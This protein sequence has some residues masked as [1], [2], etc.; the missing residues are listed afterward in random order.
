MDQ[1]AESIEKLIERA[2]EFEDRAKEAPETV[3][4][5]LPQ[6]VSFVQRGGFSRQEVMLR[7]AALESI[8]S[9]AEYE[10]TVIKKQY[11]ELIE[12]VLDTQESRLL[13]KALLH[14]SARLVDRGVSSE[15][16]VN[17]IHLGVEEAIKE[18][19]EVGDSLNADDQVPAG[20]AT[21]MHLQKHLA[22]FADT[23]TGREQLAVGALTAAFEQLVGY[24]AKQQNV[25]P[26][27]AVAEMEASYEAASRPFTEG[28]SA[29]G[30]LE[31]MMNLEETESSVYAQRYM[32]D[33]CLGA[34]I[35]VLV[36]Q[37]EP[38]ILR[39]EAVLAERIH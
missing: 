3:V 8:Y 14:D 5:D 38:R 36:E 19:R 25:D 31:D 32:I 22:E 15:A 6:L 39:T 4:S 11:P 10:P 7:D 12:A 37:T 29:D 13:A 21:A 16:V 28:F 33:G 20:G 24:R 30:R 23:I 34:S 18:V 2:E 27:D 1:S 17:G 26:V 9:L 35:I